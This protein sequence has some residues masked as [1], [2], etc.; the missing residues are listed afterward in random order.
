MPFFAMTSFLNR[1]TV[2]WQ[3]SEYT[4]PYLLFQEIVKMMEK[5]IVLEHELILSFTSETSFK[6][7]SLIRRISQIKKLLEEATV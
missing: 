7:I 1:P 6:D 4:C 5:K 2:V 3:V